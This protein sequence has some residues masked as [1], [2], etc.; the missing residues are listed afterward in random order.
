MSECGQ[1]GLMVPT[2]LLGW[3]LTKSPFF[4]MWVIGQ[5]AMYCFDGGREVEGRSI[6]D[7]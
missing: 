7:L 1:K 4:G 3:N 6:G 5:G 2:R